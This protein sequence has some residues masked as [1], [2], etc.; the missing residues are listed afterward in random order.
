MIEVDLSDNVIDEELDC[1][2][3]ETILR[4]VRSWHP[5]F[6]NYCYF[7]QSAIHMRGSQATA[8]LNN[9]YLALYPA[10]SDKQE[11]TEPRKGKRV[12][13]ELG[14]DNISTIVNDRPQKRT[15][16]KSSEPE[17]SFAQALRLIL[18]NFCQSNKSTL[19]SQLLV[20]CTTGSRNL[21]TYCVARSNNTSKLESPATRPHRLGT[22]C[23][24]YHE[25]LH[26]KTSITSQCLS[27]L[28]RQN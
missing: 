20:F 23:Q 9:R 24:T 15:K 25:T 4:V 1:I 26:A 2:A 11:L 12:A 16:S 14:E 3:A 13:S 28:T 5:T 7:T 6:K 8:S 27:I 10:V 19:V 22:W 17:D 18:L 21:L